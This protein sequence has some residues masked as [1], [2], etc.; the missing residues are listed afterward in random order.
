MFI[1]NFEQ[2]KAIMM[3]IYKDQ[4]YILALEYINVM[5]MVFPM[6]EKSSKDSRSNTPDRKPS[7]EGIKDPGVAKSFEKMARLPPFKILRRRIISELKTIG[8][9]GSLIDIGCGTGNLLVEIANKYNALDL[10]GM[11]I[12]DEILEQ[13][14]N[15]IKERNLEKKIELKIGSTEDIP[16]SDNTFDIAV[17]SLSLHHWVNPQK[18]FS[19]IFRIIKKNGSLLIFDFNRNA[20]KFYYRFLKFV[21][22]RIVPKPLKKINE[23]IGSLQA[24]YT[25]EEVLELISGLTFQNVDIKPYGAWMFIIIKK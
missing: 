20:K 7:M 1:K 23:P 10:T 3:N 16:F 12:S 5:V 2:N 9:T 6:S 15:F 11:D 17:S 8:P 18:A 22:K 13:A 25:K 21:T 14:N 24:S 4:K 19:E